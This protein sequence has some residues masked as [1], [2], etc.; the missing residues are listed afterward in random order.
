MGLGCPCAHGDGIDDQFVH[1][2]QDWVDRSICRA[3]FG[4]HQSLLEEISVQ[5]VSNL[6]KIQREVC[7][8]LRQICAP[9]APA[10]G[11]QRRAEHWFEGLDTHHG[12]FVQT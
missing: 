6:P 1:P 10:R 4:N 8:V 7:K 11:F 5:E 12:E 2:L 9:W 3:F